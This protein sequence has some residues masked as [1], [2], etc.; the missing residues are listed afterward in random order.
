[1]SY[2]YL[3]PCYRHNF[4][5]PLHRRRLCRFSLQRAV[6]ITATSADLAYTVQFFVA[7][8]HL[9]RY[10]VTNCNSHYPA[11]RRETR[12]LTG[13]SP[14]LAFVTTPIASPSLHSPLAP[15]S[16]PHLI[17]YLSGLIYSCRIC[18]RS[19]TTLLDSKDCHRQ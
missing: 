16:K 13:T 3:K 4:A 19:V 15:R 1:M 8:T 18:Q 11:A 12:T 17:I 10:S 14:D 6:Y 9:S 2:V 5:V 7:P